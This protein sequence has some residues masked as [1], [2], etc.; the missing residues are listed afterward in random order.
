MISPKRRQAQE[1]K[2]LRWILAITPRPDREPE[3]EGKIGI[4]QKQSAALYTFKQWLG[5][6]FVLSGAGQWLARRFAYS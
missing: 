3:M 6:V 1:I 2:V 4:E 5:F